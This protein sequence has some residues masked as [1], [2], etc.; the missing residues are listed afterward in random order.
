L[1][2]SPQMA[3]DRIERNADATE[4][5]LDRV[6]QSASEPRALFVTW[7]LPRELPAG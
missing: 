5:L 3:G 4:V 2:L 6:V 1:N 7:M